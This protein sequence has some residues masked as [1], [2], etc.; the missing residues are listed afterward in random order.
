MQ[1]PHVARKDLEHIDV[2]PVAESRPTVGNGDRVERQRYRHKPECHVLARTTGRGHH[3]GKCGGRQI[4]HNG[5]PEH[6]RFKRSSVSR[7]DVTHHALPPPP[8]FSSHR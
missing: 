7:D 8:E 4:D 6:L 1:A 5:D 3:Y 2:G